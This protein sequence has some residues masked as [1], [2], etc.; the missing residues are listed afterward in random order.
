MWAFRHRIVLSTLVVGVLAGCSSPERPS[1]RGVTLVL[2]ASVQARHGT[3]A[4]CEVSTWV[5]AEFPVIVGD[6][7]GPGGT[8]AT[9]ETTAVNTTR[10]GALA[11]NAR[12][13]ADYAYTRTA[14]PAGGT[15]EVLAGIVIAPPPPPRDAV[16]INVVVAL[17]DGR[18]SIGSA[19][20]V[21]TAE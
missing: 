2:P 10:G 12:P 15:L 17:A 8:L 7:E 9:V 19:P 3:C 18:K 1:A 14:V 4:T 5:F 21:V 13:N 16:R 6:P 20:L 11:H